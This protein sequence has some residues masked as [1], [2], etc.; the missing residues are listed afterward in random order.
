MGQVGNSWPQVFSLIGN[1]DLLHLSY[2]HVRAKMERLM[3]VYAIWLVMTVFLMI[4]GF[5]N[6]ITHHHLA[7]STLYSGPEYKQ[8]YPTSVFFNQNDFAT[9]LSISFFFTSR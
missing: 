7:S 5:Y 2:C 6:H 1:G 4:I 9:F 8:H 3:I